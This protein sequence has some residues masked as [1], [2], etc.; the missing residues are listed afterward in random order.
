MNY[1]IHNNYLMLFSYRMGPSSLRNSFELSPSHR[2]AIL[3]RN[4]VVSHIFLILS[5][6]M[7]DH[8]RNLICV[9]EEQKT[10][11]MSFI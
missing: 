11:Q 8:E 2:G 4:C 1:L 7:P 6:N 10:V 9:L 5:L 3:T